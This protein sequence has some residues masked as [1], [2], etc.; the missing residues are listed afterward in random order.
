MISNQLLCHYLWDDGPDEEALLSRLPPLQWLQFGSSWHDSSQHK[1]VG[2]SGSDGFVP[3]V[4]CLRV[5]EGWESQVHFITLTRYW[6]SF[7]MIK[8]KI[9]DLEH[10]GQALYPWA[11]P[12]ALTISSTDLSIFFFIDCRI[13]SW[14]QF[15]ARVLSFYWHRCFRVA[16]ALQALLQR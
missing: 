9:R 8:I 5:P 7:L 11:R 4:F 14:L 16:V 15:N 10:T 3:G 1:P 12:L 6:I 2:L 13:V